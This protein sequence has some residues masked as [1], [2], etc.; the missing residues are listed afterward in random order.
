MPRESEPKCAVC[1]CT[2]DNACDGGCWWVNDREI[3][4]CSA[5]EEAWKRAKRTLRML[6]R[7]QA[8]CNDK[9]IVARAMRRL[10]DWTAKKL[11]VQP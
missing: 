2:Q 7:S 11:G 8:P 3:L 10:Q 5:C 1:G 9:L 6:A 4:L